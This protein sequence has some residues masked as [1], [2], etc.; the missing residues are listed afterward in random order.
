MLAGRRRPRGPRMTVEDDGRGWRPK[1]RPCSGVAVSNPSPVPWSMRGSASRGLTLGVRGWSPT[2]RAG[3][4][5]CSTP[6]STAGT[7]P[8]AGSSA[9]R[10]PR[11][12]LVREMQEEAGVR[13][14]A[15]R[16]WSRCTATSRAIPATTCWSIASTPG[17][18]APPAPRARSTRSAGS[19]PT[20]CR[21][22]PPQHAPAHRRGVARRRMRPDVVS[23]AELAIS[24]SPVINDH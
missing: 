13:C 1:L 19:R 15:A 8:A 7:C 21:P 12:A 22:T 6:M 14:W 16:P 23:G 17:S 5:W 24:P 4:C 10:R 2:A 9:A 3:C 11:Q 20:P 18:P